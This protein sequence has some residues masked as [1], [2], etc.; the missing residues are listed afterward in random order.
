MVHAWGE[1]AK[2]LDGVSFAVVFGIIAGLVSPFAAFATLVYT[3]I[4]IYETPTVQCWL[5]RRRLKSHSS[6]VQDEKDYKEHRNG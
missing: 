3:L 4:R 1:V 5:R 2:F 6:D